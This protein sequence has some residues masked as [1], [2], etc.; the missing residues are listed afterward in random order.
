MEGYQTAF[1]PLLAIVGSPS[2]FADDCWVNNFQF[3]DLLLCFTHKGFAIFS[4]VVRTEPARKIEKQ[5]E[6]KKKKQK[7]GMRCIVL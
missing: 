2:C 3:F 7:E 6:E 4:Y 5:K 1:V